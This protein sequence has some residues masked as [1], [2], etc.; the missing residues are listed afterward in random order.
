MKTKRY[1][2]DIILILLIFTTLVLTVQIWMGSNPV[3]NGNKS[4]FSV[5]VDPIVQLFSHEQEDSLS[6]SLENLMCPQ[7]IVLNQSTKRAVLYSSDDFFSKVHDACDILMKKYCR[8]TLKILSKETVPEEVYYSALKENSIYI[9]YGN[10]YDYRLFFNSV[11]GEANKDSNGDIGSL[12]EYIISLNDN[13]LNNVT[14]YI[15]DYRSGN[16]YRYIVEEDKETY[17]RLLTEYF[18]DKGAQILNYSFELNFHKQESG[19]G[20]L[21][22]LVFEPKILF[23]LSPVESSV[24]SPD[25]ES[26]HDWSALGSETIVDLL[27]AFQVNPMTMRKYTD[28]TNARVYVE[29]DATLMLYPGGILKYHAVE[30]GKGLPLVSSSDKGTFDIYSAVTSAVNFV[31]D[32]NHKFPQNN[33]SSLRLSCDLGENTASKTYQ[34]T[35]DVYVNGLPVLQIDPD[36][37][38]NCHAIEMTISDGHLKY[39]RQFFHQYKTEN[40]SETIPPVIGAMDDLV[41]RLNPQEESIYVLNIARC[42]VDQ[43]NHEPLRP[44]WMVSVNGMDKII[45]VK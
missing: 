9:N 17:D 44:Q 25:N 35:F 8:S 18:S 15:Q 43:K 2:K 3:V 30:G 1:V 6:D 19:V 45:T 33:T 42:Y 21:T 29:N 14:I 27:N 13:I 5:I 10:I 37:G 36:T 41:D 7:K 39:Y 38:E 40:T 22:K 32:L 26:F 34:F 31:V 16:I 20:T 4:V 12:R 23:H 28:L 24:I 11:C